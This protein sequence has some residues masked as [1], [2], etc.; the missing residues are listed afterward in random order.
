MIR[1]PPPHP[2]GATPPP[3][4]ADQVPQHVVDL[5]PQTGFGPAAK[6]SVHRL[7]GREL[8][9]QGTPGDPALVQVEDRVQDPAAVVLLGTPAPAALFTIPL[10]SS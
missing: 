7:V 6:E 4:S 3:L 1:K 9:G 5:L 10:T 8:L 2:S